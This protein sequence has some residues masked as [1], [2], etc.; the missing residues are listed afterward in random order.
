[1]NFIIRILLLVFM[2]LGLTTSACIANARVQ[3]W[4]LRIISWAVFAHLVI[5]GFALLLAANS[6]RTSE[7]Y[8]IGLSPA[9][10]AFGS[11]FSYVVGFAGFW[12]VK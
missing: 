7:G 4:S 1:M 2:L 9:A 11:F 12:F 5:I 3:G 8:R 10:C 6:K